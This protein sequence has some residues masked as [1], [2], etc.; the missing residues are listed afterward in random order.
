MRYT[1]VSRIL[2]S[3][4]LLGMAFVALQ[5]PSLYAAGQQ[6][7]QPPIEP[8][9][10]SSD[11]LNWA[12]YT[13]TAG[14]SYTSVSGSWIVPT[15][16]NGSVGRAD[17]TWVGIGGVT[18]HDLIQAGT[19]AIVAPGGLQYQ[20]WYELLPDVSTPVNLVVSPGDSM[21]TTITEQSPNT[22]DIVIHN[23]TTGKEYSKVV[24][25]HSSHSSAEWI[26][27]RVSDIDGSFYPLS[28]FGS[29]TFQQ[30]MAEVDGQ[31]KTMPQL[32]AKPLTMQSSVGQILATTSPL[33][34]G[35]AFTVTHAA[36]TA[37]PAYA[38]A[39]V[40][41]QVVQLQPDTVSSDGSQV[42]VITFGP[43]G[44]SVDHTSD[45]S[46]GG[47]IVIPTRRHRSWHY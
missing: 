46:A 22:W 42:I 12:G 44:I 8:T 21:T 33:S 7:E 5:A 10:S 3:L 15:V 13:A 20:A 28:D 35:G 39:S 47:Y 45:S 19:Q 43:G 36:H 6:N 2:G 25:Y 32:N 4:L 41:P 18:S 29:V 26:E 31:L 1:L 9:G 17:A 30:A 34:P 16:Q 24:N 11:S 27:E 14:S 40:G 37:Q 38:V 23:N